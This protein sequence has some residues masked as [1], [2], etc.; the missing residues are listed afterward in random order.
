MELKNF[1]PP[2]RPVDLRPAFRIIPSRFPPVSL[3][4]DVADPADLDTVYQVECLTNDRLRDEVG[5][6]QLVAPEERI[7]G[8][9][10]GYIMAAFTH[11]SVE[12]GRFHDGS[13]GSFYAAGD[14]PTAVAETVYHRER[15]L[16]HSQAPA[17]EI[18]MRVL[19]ARV[20][21]EMHDIR[22]M[23]DELPAVYHPTD[24]S[25]GQALARTLRA[26]GSWGI[27]YDSVRRD[28]GECFAVLRPRAV[29]ECKQAEH[30][31]YAWDGEAIDLVYEK[32]I[33]RR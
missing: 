8:P 15:F 28:G 30:L 24:Y 22:G 33:V 6:L 32:R 13:Y 1:R 7:S 16:R 31:G 27:G 23:R 2:L 10:T 21:A 5:D 19:R 17:Q 29:T 9:G 26:E 14:R 4:E 20:S 18:D 12:G 3:F 25:A 11:V